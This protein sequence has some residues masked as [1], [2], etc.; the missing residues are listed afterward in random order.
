MPNSS[1]NAQTVLHWLIHTWTDIDSSLHTYMYIPAAQTHTCSCTR[2]WLTWWL[3]LKHRGL[4]LMFVCV[5][6]CLPGA[7]VIQSLSSQ[8]AAWRLPELIFQ[9]LRI[10]FYRFPPRQS[11]HQ[12]I[13]TKT[14]GALRV[15]SAG[16]G[17]P[18]EAT[19]KWNQFLAASR[20]ILRANIFMCTKR[21]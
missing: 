21:N 1:H 16:D 17:A 14:T 13:L 3:N 12:H 7:N 19:A 11:K 6:L 9:R 15:G 8:P 10:D 5:Y 4:S 2:H 18:E 20:W